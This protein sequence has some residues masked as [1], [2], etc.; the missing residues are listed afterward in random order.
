[1]CIPA[2][3]ALLMQ[4]TA[5]EQ[6]QINQYIDHMWSSIQES[7]AKGEEYTWGQR[8]FMKDV[9]AFKKTMPRLSVWQKIMAWFGF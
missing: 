2:T 7:D 3:H 4:T 6:R 8:E 5:E 9:T 1:M